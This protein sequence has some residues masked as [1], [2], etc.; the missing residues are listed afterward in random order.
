MVA[1]GHLFYLLWLILLQISPLPLF[2]PSPGGKGW[3]GGLQQGGDQGRSV[4]LGTWLRVLAAHKPT[5]K[6]ACSLGLG[7]TQ[8]LSSSALRLSAV[9]QLCESSLP[10][11]RRPGLQELQVLRVRRSVVLRN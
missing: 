4:W 10:G 9:G 5:P 2:N 3:A 11:V 7:L 8:L 1:A 6:P